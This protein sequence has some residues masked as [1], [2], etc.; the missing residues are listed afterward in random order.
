[1]SLLLENLAIKLSFLHV[2]FFPDFFVPQ[3]GLIFWSLLTAW[4]ESEHWKIMGKF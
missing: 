3:V 2:C 1:M 4:D